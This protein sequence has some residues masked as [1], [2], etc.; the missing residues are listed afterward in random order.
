MWFNFIEFGSTTSRFSNQPQSALIPFAMAE[1]LGFASHFERT[2]SKAVLYGPDLFRS[3]DSRWIIVP[4][5]A[6][7][8][9]LFKLPQPAHVQTKLCTPNKNI[10]S[11]R[12]VRVDSHRQLSTFHTFR[13]SAK[14]Q[15]GLAAGFE[16]QKFNSN[17]YESSL[18]DACGHQHHLSLRFVFGGCDVTPFLFGPS[19]PPT[20]LSDPPEFS[21]PALCRH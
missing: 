18:L 8:F 1:R 3:N 9:V 19:H 15:H 21:K 7:F 20:R 13:V 14:K 4:R 6:L 2:L 12:A 17:R 5:P 10:N 11:E 16:D